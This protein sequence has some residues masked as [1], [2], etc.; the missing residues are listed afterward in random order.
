MK[1]AEIRILRETWGRPAFCR[2]EVREDGIITNIYEGTR[3]QV[4]MSCRRD[5]YRGKIH[6]F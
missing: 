1:R 3:K 2:I 6:K 5:G 4:R